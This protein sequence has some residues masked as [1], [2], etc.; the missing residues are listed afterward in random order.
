LT[1]KAQEILEQSINSYSDQLENYWNDVD[2]L[3]EHIN[4]TL[5]A[6]PQVVRHLKRELE[7]RIHNF[8]SLY[9]DFCAFLERERT[10]KCQQELDRVRMSRRGYDILFDAVF[11]RL[12]GALQR[13]SPH[14]QEIQIQQEEKVRSNRSHGNSSQNSSRSRQSSLLSE[15]KK[16]AEIPRVKLKYTEQEIQMKKEQS[17][18][19][20][21]RAKSQKKV[22][23]WRQI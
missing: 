8:D 4:L 7:S 11:R 5:P 1:A 12:N 23:I 17:L 15:K 14:E 18:L 22:M 21:E 3:I 9:S 2:K 19:A 20:L 16:K 13:P 10:E 6:D